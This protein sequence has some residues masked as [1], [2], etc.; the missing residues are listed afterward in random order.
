MKF[1]NFHA[2]RNHL[3]TTLQYTLFQN[4][5]PHPHFYYKMQVVG[6]L[7]HLKCMTLETMNILIGC[8]ITHSMNLLQLNTQ[9]IQYILYTFGVFHMK[10]N[11]II[12]FKA[13]KISLLLITHLNSNH[14][15]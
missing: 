8:T 12:T 15:L 9:Y 4:K 11:L 7:H 13:V 5:Q 10:Y 2:F 6:R 14:P 3:S 1:V